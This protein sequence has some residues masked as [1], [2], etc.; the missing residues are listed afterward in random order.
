MQRGRWEEPRIFTVIQAAGDVSDDEMEHVFNL[1]LGMLAIVAGGDARRARSTRCAAAA[2]RRGSSAWSTTATDARSS[3]VVRRRSRPGEAAMPCLG[4]LV[5]FAHMVPP[6]ATN[7][8]RAASTPD[9]ASTPPHEPEELLTPS[10]VA[11]M[12]RV[13]PKTVTRWAPHGQDLGHPHARR[14]PPVPRHRDPEAPR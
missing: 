9:D 2:T 10:E 13:N 8:T 7:G 1:G 12:F 11:A 3:I 5:R 6:T 4:P 14:P